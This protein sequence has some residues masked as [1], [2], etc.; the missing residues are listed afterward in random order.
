MAWPVEIKLLVNRH[1]VEIGPR[2]SRLSTAIGGDLLST[3]S[4]RC[5]AGRWDY[6]ELVPDCRQ[7]STL[8]GGE[9]QSSPRRAS[10]AGGGQWGGLAWSPATRGL[11]SLTLLKLPLL[12]RSL[13]RLSNRGGHYANAVHMANRCFENYH[14]RAGASASRRRNPRRLGRGGC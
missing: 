3:V 12:R 5:C 8:T 11:D 10:C 13:I 6:R 9:R 2:L 4:T 7:G 14:S 1:S